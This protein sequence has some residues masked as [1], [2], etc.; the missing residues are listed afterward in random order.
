M[1]PKQLKEAQN[2]S[3]TQ[4]P[5][6][7]DAQQNFNT[8]IDD[9]DKFINENSAGLDVQFDFASV[10]DALFKTQQAIK[11]I[12]NMLEKSGGVG[13]ESCSHPVPEVSSLNGSHNHESS[14]ES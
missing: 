4:N 12:E 3:Q 6:V 11:T 10:T 9:V 1:N 14:N 8:S 2:S 13:A 5:K 7:A